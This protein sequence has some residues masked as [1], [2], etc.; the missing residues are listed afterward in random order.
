MNHLERALDNQ[1]KWWKPLLVILGIIGATV[2]VQILLVVIY[3]FANFSAPMLESMQDDP[4]LLL[5]QMRGDQNFMFPLIF[6]S[7]LASIVVGALVIWALYK[8]NFKEVINGTQKVRWD[9]FFF[10]FGVW[11]GLMAIYLLLSYLF[12]P[13]GFTFSFN[14]YNFIILLILSIIAIPFQASFEEFVFRGYLAQL[15]ASW[16]KSRWS[17]II[18]PAIIF[19]LMHIVNPEVEKY[20]VLMMMPQYIFMGVV[21]GLMSV[22]DDGIEC[23]MGAHTANNIFLCVFLTFDGSVLPTDAI[24]RAAN[25]N[26]IGDFISII[27]MSVLFIFTL[28]FFFQWNFKILS[29]RIEP[30]KKADLD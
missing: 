27:I 13:R 6:M 25:I 24:F 7:S 18:F 4:D 14:F 5:E 21:F 22:L 20:G 11:F 17:S 19:G 16:T 15:V 29:S 9:R 12:N 10:S 2:I 28:G 1:N 23:A 30:K 8:R 26:P 3:I